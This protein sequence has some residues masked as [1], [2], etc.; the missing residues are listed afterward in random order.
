MPTVQHSLRIIESSESAVRLAEA[1]AWLVARVER[2]ALVVS[3]SRGAAD[4]LA[5]G[6]ALERGGAVG[7]HRFSFAQLA[8]SLAAPVLAARGIA[9]ATRIGS[10]AVAARAAFEA[11]KENGLEDFAPIA[12]TPSALTRSSVARSPNGIVISV[13]GADS[14]SRRASASSTVVSSGTSSSRSGSPRSGRVDAMAA[15]N[16]AARSVAPASSNC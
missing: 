16:S 10:E 3:A 6:V 4:D 5:R 9:P 8:A 15:S 1:R 11:A 7:L 2:G 14:I 13:S 12:S